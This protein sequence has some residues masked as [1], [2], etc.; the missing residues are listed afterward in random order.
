MKDAYKKPRKR[1]IDKLQPE[2]EKYEVSNLHIAAAKNNLTRVK[3]CLY[4]ENIDVNQKDAGGNTPL[5]YAARYNNCK[6]A[7]YLLKAGAEVDERNNHDQTPLH[8]AHQAFALEVREILRDRDASTK[9]RDVFGRCPGITKKIRVPKNKAI[10]L[11]AG[12]KELTEI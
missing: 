8:Y 3:A 7:E 6:V 11:L 1:E 10:P 5:H 9:A 4:N 12:M 2:L